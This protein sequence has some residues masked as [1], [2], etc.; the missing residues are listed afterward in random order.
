MGIV[1][2]HKGTIECIEVSSTEAVH[3]FVEQSNVK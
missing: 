3:W 2:V 1:W